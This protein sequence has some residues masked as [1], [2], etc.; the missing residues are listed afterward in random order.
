M[1]LLQLSHD[2]LSLLLAICRVH[3]LQFL[4]AGVSVGNYGLHGKEAGSDLARQSTAPITRRMNCLLKFTSLDYGF[5]C[6][7]S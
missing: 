1:K 4:T 5:R 3:A 6:V 7:L 2:F